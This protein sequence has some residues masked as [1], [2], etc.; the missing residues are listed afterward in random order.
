[1]ERTIRTASAGVAVLLVAVLSLFL[2]LGLGGHAATRNALREAL[3]SALAD[4]ILGQAG[5]FSLEREVLD[6]LDSTF[7]KPVD[8]ASL[9]DDAVRGLVQ[10]LG[11]DYTNYLS[12]QDF[13][14]FQERA[15]GQYSGVGMS[16]EMKSTFVTVVS[17]FKGSP[18]E[19][20]GVQPGDVVL[21]V[22]DE[23]V[24][25]LS[26]DE[27]VT[28]IKGEE[29]TTVK[30]KIYRLPPG[31]S[32]PEESPTDGAHLP[33]GGTVE[34]LTLTRKTII[35]P[36][37]ESETLTAG[38][39]TVAH[40]RFS[41]F[42]EESAARLRQAVETALSS[43]KVDVIV[44][45]LRNNG[46]GLLTEAV[47]AA[48]IFIPDG[49]IVTTEGLHSPP[50]VYEAEGDPITG[51]PVYMLINGF[52]ASASEIVAGALK[53][54]GRATLVGEKT[55]GKG[56]VQTVIGLSNGGAL[57]VTTAVYRTPSG[58]DINKKG[59]QPDVEMPDDPATPDVDE[60]LQ[61][62][63]DLIAAP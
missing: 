40:I 58:A 52:S 13:A 39:H 27:V 43:D 11:D 34:E 62:A 50:E 31:S 55:F 41:T 6:K 3:P 12:P 45:D 57:K 16:V 1:M 5:D 44:L 14:S 61:K 49:V 20:S 19:Q 46:G 28:R 10:G 18:A 7:Y 53:D 26:L 9:M 36:V 17:T 59:I 56:L 25:G 63:L 24:A 22:D 47:R 37:V 48:S 2:G 29:G 51:V 33:Q 32:G 60:T 4:T 38:T 35:I 15:G 8:E 30:L 23:D 54:T 21:A 42:S